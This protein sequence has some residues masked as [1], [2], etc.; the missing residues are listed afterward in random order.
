MKI[1]ITGGAGFIGINAAAYFLQKGDQVTI[2]DN[3]SRKGGKVNIDWLINEKGYSPSIIEG[4]LKTDISKL[5]EPLKDTDIVLHL[6]GQVAVTTS[7]KNPR[8]DFEDN[9]L[10]TFNVLEATRLSGN[11]PVF[12]YSSTNKVYGG[13]ENISIIENKTRYAFKNIKEGVSEEQNLDFHSPYGC[14]KGSADQY[15]RDYSRIYGLNTIVF[16]QSCIYG[17]RQFGIEDQGWVAWFIIALMTGKQI[18]IY[19]NGKQVRDILFVTDLVKAYDMASANIIKTKGQIYNIGGGSQNTIS[20]WYEFVP[21]LENLF[22]TS[23][24]ASFEAIRP[25]DQP[26]YISDIKKAENDF[27]WKPSI[28]VD[29][30]IKKLYTWVSDNKQLFLE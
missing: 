21:I 16:R 10:G 24:N 23:I 30:G 2:F 5:Q 22:N 19:G 25:G 28:S 26:I 6:A 13:L 18:T 11:N 9:A 15:V 17:P 7:V 14:S 8:E 20:V 3:F 29:E 1:L 4:D 12:I 27:G